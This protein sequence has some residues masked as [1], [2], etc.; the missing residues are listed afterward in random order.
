M[1]DPIHL[2]VLSNPTASHLR[3]LNQIKDPVEILAGNDPEFIATHAPGAD[4]I[5]VGSAEGHLLNTAFPLAKKVRWVHSLAAG[6][7]KMIFPQLVESSVP[8]TNGKGIFSESLAEFAIAAILFFAKDLRRLVRSQQAG[9]WDQFDIEVIHGQTLGIVGYGDIGRQ[10]AGL[11][12][13]F[14]MKVVAVRRN[15]AQSNQDPDLERVFSPD[16]LLEMLALCDY[17]LVATPLTPETRGMIGAQQLSA[18]KPTAVIINL[19]RGPVI[20]ESA[21][22]AALSEKRIRGAALDVFDE[23]PLPAGHPF[24]ALENVLLSPHSADHTVGWADLGMKLFLEN[25]GRFYN[26]QPL[27]NIVDKRAGY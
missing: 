2:L 25:F 17:V 8:V 27:Q 3:L 24:Y 21:L 5:L 13:A 20:T 7:E 22:I 19:G 12:R 26:G 10:T 11:A 4:V 9:K 18:M 15:A 23:E 16:H 6:V 14:G 1:Q